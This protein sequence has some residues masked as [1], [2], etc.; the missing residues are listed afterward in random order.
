MAGLNQSGKLEINTV[1]LHYV[2]TIFSS[3]KCSLFSVKIAEYYGL[4]V[5]L[6]NSHVDVQMPN[7]MALRRRTLGR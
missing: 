4:N 5:P 6:Q 2:L 3:R 7:V 1:P